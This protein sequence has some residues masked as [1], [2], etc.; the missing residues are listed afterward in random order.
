MVGELGVQLGEPGRRVGPSVAPVDFSG[1]PRLM[2]AE[3]LAHDDEILE[4]AVPGHELASARTRAA[5][6]AL[7]AVP[8]ATLRG[9][10]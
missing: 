10:R 5:S 1:A 6:V 7:L 8:Q 2:L 9:Q 4:D 3:Q